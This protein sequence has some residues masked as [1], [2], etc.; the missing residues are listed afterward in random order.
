MP[1]QLPQSGQPEVLGQ[2]LRRLYTPQVGLDVE[3]DVDVMF[4][5]RWWVVCVELC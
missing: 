3:V 2:D 5:C 1:Q 4:P